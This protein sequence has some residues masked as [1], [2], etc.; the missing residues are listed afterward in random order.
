MGELIRARRGLN[1]PS[2]VA[3]AVLALLVVFA[4]RAW[5]GDRSI[6]D[7]I[8]FCGNE[9]IQ[10]LPAPTTAERAVSF[11]RSC[12]AT[13]GFGTMISLVAREARVPSGPGTIFRAEWSAGQPPA[14]QGY[15]A[16]PPVRMRWAT[17][18]TLEVVIHHGA[19]PFL[20]VTRF[21]SVTIRYRTDKIPPPSQASQSNTA[22][23]RMPGQA[24]AQKISGG[25]A[26]HR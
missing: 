22:F 7:L 9:V 11:T 13:T 18:D 23:Q 24:A 14:A 16:G 5:I 17:P 2:L 21:G 25:A 20:V 26:R 3:G 15:P 19:D 4:A 6:A 8:G 1:I 12:G 10:D